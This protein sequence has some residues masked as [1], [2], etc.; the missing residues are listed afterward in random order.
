MDFDLQLDAK[1]ISDAS[2]AGE[3]GLRTPTVEQNNTFKQ[4]KE[5]GLG[6]WTEAF[7]IRDTSIGPPK[8]GGD[9]PVIKVV[10]EVL[11]AADGGFDFNAGSQQFAVYYIDRGALSDKADR[12]H[13]MNLQR[14]AS[15]KSL[16]VA[17]GYTMPTEGTLSFAS[18]LN[19]DK[20]LIGQKVAGV[21]RKYTY[22]NKTTGEV[23][24]QCEV[25]AFLSLSN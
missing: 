3:R 7:V 1:T 17:C 13:R 20:P 25:D 23:V 21:V 12:L 10:L 6:T 22:T 11:G 16:F 5:E 14:V 18:L 8:N 2:E 4:G 19:N 15:V 24:K 9:N